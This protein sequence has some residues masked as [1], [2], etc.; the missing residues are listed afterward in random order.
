MKIVF[1]LTSPENV[2][3]VVTEHRAVLDPVEALEREGLRVTWLGVDECGHVD[4]DR[5]SDAI[6]NR[7][8]LVS[9]M[10]ANNETGVLQP[11]DRIGALCRE[12][13]ALF[14][15]DATQSLGKETIDV[16]AAGIDLLSA[17]AHKVHGPKG[18]GFLYARRKRPRVRIEPLLRGGGHERGMRSGTLNV[19]GIV[20]LAA[21]CELATDPAEREVEQARVRALRD[22]L[23]ERLASRLADEGALAGEVTVNG[24]PASRGRVAGIVNLSFPGIDGEKLMQRMR[25]VAVSSASACT[26]ATLQPSHVLGAHG[27]SE[28]RI[29]GS[30]RFSLGRFTTDSDIE[31]AINSVVRACVGLRAESPSGGGVDACSGVDVPSP[32]DGTR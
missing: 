16:D 10:H 18:V 14:H 3:T 15:T 27:L 13:G 2:V 5:L 29:R 12:R 23:Q 1:A 6:T 31:G 22:R 28:E 20:G 7:T 17:S 25:D 4:L 11:I 21:A 26:S 24:D 8:L 19:P 9:V 32:P 30:V